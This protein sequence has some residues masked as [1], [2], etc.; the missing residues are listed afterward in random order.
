M[1]LLPDNSKEMADAVEKSKQYQREYYLKHAEK[2][3]AY[4]RAWCKSKHGKQKRAAQRRRAG[5]RELNRL[6]APVPRKEDVS[7]YN[8]YHHHERVILKRLTDKIK[9]FQKVSGLK[10]PICCKCGEYNV[11]VLC[12]NH[13]NGGGRKEL[14]GNKYYLFI[15]GILNG[16]RGVDDLDVRCQNCNTLYEYERGHRKYHRDWEKLYKELTNV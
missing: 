9:A 8:K 11:Y 12:I 4:S 3:K 14:A 6:N 15:K 2:K 5:I 13:I 1:S 10:T 16:E 7:A